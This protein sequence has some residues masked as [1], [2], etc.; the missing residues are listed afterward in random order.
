MLVQIQ[1]RLVAVMGGAG[2]LLGMFGV[3]HF[4]GQSLAPVITETEN[5]SNVLTRQGSNNDLRVKEV[6]LTP[7]L[8][9]GLGGPLSLLAT[10]GLSTLAKMV[11]LPQEMTVSELAKVDSQTVLAAGGVVFAASAL[12]RYFSVRYMIN[13]GK[14]TDEGFQLKTLC[15]RGPYGLFRHPI[16][17]GVFGCTLAAPLV[18]D[19]VYACAGP[20]VYCAWAWGF[21]IPDEERAMR[22]K[23]TEEYKAYCNK[24]AI[25]YIWE[26]VMRR[27]K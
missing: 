6:Q 17:V 7:C 4:S 10:Y 5:S 25:S 23:F 24:S 18:L 3:V 14:Q 2:A 16:Y 11:M 1:D 27:L 12:L 13:I 15:T 22:D 9:V 8:A 26:A 21:I 20:L 19:S